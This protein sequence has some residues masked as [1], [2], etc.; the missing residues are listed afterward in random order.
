M[1]TLASLLLLVAA[2]GIPRPPT[3]PEGAVRDLA[4]RAPLTVFVFFSA[5]CPCQAAHDGRLVALDARYRP[6][7]V[8]FFAIDS[9]VGASEER[10]ATEAARRHYTFPILID[11]VAQVARRVGAEFATYT[12]VVDTGG[13]IRYRGGIDSDRSHLTDDATPYLGDALDDLLAGRPPGT[14][15]AKTLGCALEKP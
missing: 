15:E 12:I 14:A 1:R 9:E 2:C 5:H 13:T 10:A 3:L 7:G 4:A 8:Q 6:R 11:K